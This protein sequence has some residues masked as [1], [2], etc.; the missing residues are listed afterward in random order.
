MLKLSVQPVAGPPFERAFEGGTMILGRA[1]DCDLVLDD[2]FLSRHHSRLSK[3]GD[4]LLLEDLGSRN[5]TLLNGSPVK[6][7]T[8]VKAGDVIRIS[9]S[10]ITLR[11]ESL[12]EE[13]SVPSTLV[14]ELGEHTI[15][16]SASGLLEKA[17][18]RTEGDEKALQRYA[19]RLELL[20]EVHRALGQSME[21]GELLD[22]ILDRVFDHLQPEQGAIF[23]KRK[24][25]SDSDGDD[26][27]QAALRE[28]PGINR[29]F[30]CSR[31]LIR[32]VSEKGVAA[33]VYDIADDERF[34]AAQSL[35]ITGL[36][37]LMAAPLLDP[38][39]SLGMIVLSS[40]GNRRFNE[41]DMELLVSLANVAGLAL[42]NVALAEEAAER[43]RLEKELA[44]GRQIQNA[45]LPDTLPN[46]PGIELFARNLPHSG[47]SGDFYQVLERTGEGNCLL[48]VADVSGK[49]IGAALLTASLEAL[50]AGPIEDG[51]PP[52][53]ICTAIS[54]RLYSRTPTEKYATAVLATL[55]TQS[56]YLRYVNA[57]H[58]PGLV[59]RRGG[60]EAE[61]LEAT[62]PPIGI[63]ADAEFEFGHIHLGPGDLLALYTDGIT[64]ALDPEEEEY[65]QER[66]AYLLGQHRDRPLDD[67]VAALREDLFRF[68]DGTPFSDD[69]TLVLA[70][71]TVET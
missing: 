46:I 12:R 64:E 2:R 1:G 22:L 53:V 36:Q 63:L 65:G 57:G 49:G 58:N 35:L 67:I 56:G 18:S 8:P 41:G 52:E 68:A 55:N 24:G 27:E 23:L 4:R 44:L 54:R 14:K 17:S 62:G 40:S 21:L 33:L 19:E 7:P 3:E 43:R 5:G 31:S 26:Y 10:T 15:F 25:D 47:V 13:P 38:K 59:L 28:Q 6:A 50:A 66:L 29:P 16:R 71:R 39:G 42:R 48:M 30:S 37:S 69:R 11:A 34:A 60:G 9:G 70:R 20:N 32:E 51:Q 61:T 45:L